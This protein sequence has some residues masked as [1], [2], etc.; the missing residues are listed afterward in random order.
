VSIALDPRALIE[1]EARALLTRAH[2]VRPLALTETT[3]V[4]ASF[5]MDAQAAIERLLSQGRHDC[6]P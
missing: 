4:A 6:R 2:R 5:S 3:V 1:A